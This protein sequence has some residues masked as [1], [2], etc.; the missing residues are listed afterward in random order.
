MRGSPRIGPP[1]WSFPFGFGAV[2][3]DRSADLGPFVEKICRISLVEE[4]AN[5]AFRYGVARNRFET[6]DEVVAQSI[7]WFRL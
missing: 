7:L 5:P 3:L 4:P 6:V 2:D 1:K